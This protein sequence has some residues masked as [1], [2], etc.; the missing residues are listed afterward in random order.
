MQQ[1]GNQLLPPGHPAVKL[2]E[3]VVERL[4]PVTGME[5]VHWKVYVI[6]SDIPNAFVIPGG[7]IFVFRVPS[8]PPPAFT[9]ALTIRGFY[10]LRR[11]RMVWRRYWD[12]RLLIIRY[13]I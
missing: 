4:G 2:C 5:G 13:D 8:R 10:Q 9:P 1:F 12:M 6:D 3:R 11:M 7:Q